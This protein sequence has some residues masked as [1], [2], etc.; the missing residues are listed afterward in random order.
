[1]SRATA[2]ME[3]RSTVRLS[4]TRRR[5][6]GASLVEVMVALTIGLLILTA[7]AELISHN[8]ATRSEIDRTGRQ[9]ENGRYAIELLRDD[10]RMAG[11]FSGFDDTGATRQATSPCVPG[12][13]IGLSAANLGWQTA[14]VSM[15]LGV[16]GIAGGDLSAS[17][18][19]ISNQKPNTDVLIVRRLESEPLIVATIAGAA[20]ANDY[21]MQLS[22]CSDSTI[23]PVNMPF[24]VAT[25]G[26]ATPFTLHEMKCITPSKVR[27][28]VV[29][30]YYV[31]TCSD[32]QN[33]GDGIPTLRMVELNGGATSNLPL[34]EG[35]ESMRV[36]F[37]VDNDGNGTIDTVKRCKSGIDA[38]TVADWR[39]VMAVQ[40]RLLSRNLTKS[41]GY[42][43]AKTYDMGLAGTIAA[44]ND[45]YKRHSYSSLVIVYNHTGPREQ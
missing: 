24:V 27:K 15:P 30:A 17:D 45:G 7:L 8:S 42:T 39:N 10:I 23:D 1:M 33:G 11:F 31:A 44:P 21:Y 9:I 25:G 4:A 26:S 36:E 5:E 2:K 13:S 18:S 43:D 29:R 37:S 38:C 3:R 35:I 22:R 32:C 28:V 41:A 19:C 16:H 40:V 34:V 14:P 20:Y 6:R 12:S